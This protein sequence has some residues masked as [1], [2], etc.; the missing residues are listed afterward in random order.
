MQRKILTFKNDAGQLE[1][2]IPY[3]DDLA[4]QIDGTNL[5]DYLAQIEDNLEVAKLFLG[6]FTSESALL[7]KYPDGIVLPVGTYAIVS[8]SDSLYIYDTD[9]LRWLKTA[10]AT[11]GILQLNGLSPINGSLTITG[12]DIQSTVSNADTKTQTI[13]NHLDTLYSKAKQHD[14]ANTGMIAVP[15]SYDGF[16]EKDRVITYK[17]KVANYGKGAYF[18]FLEFRGLS[19]NDAVTAEKGVDLE[20]TY[21]DGTVITKSLYTADYQRVTI[22]LLKIFIGLENA[23]TVRTTLIKMSDSMSAYVLTMN[24]SAITNPIMATA[25]ITTANWIDNEE[26]A[27]YKYVITAPSSTYTSSYTVISVSKVSNSVYTT[28][29]VDYKVNGNVI[30]LYSDTKFSG[31]MNYMYKMG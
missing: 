23:Q 13:T 20:I 2:L 31:K 14:S 19:T 7:A 28:A 3:V 8:D 9:N 18:T 1:D 26:G 10:S 16:V 25:S 15:Y 21:S 29:I 30:T 24:T 17:V 27:G 6:A 5:K 4:V 22:N 11:V 12:G